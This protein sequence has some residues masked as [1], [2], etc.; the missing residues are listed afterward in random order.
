MADTEQPMDHVPPDDGV[1]REESSGLE[2]H[3]KSRRTWIRLLFMVL[4]GVAW[5]LAGLITW[6]VI[7]VNFLYVLFSGETN[8]QLTAFGHSLGMYLFQ[9][10]DFMT[11][12]TESRPFPIDEDWPTAA[13]ESDDQS[14]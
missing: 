9:I 1:A 12:N 3:V 10:V 11:F 13:A 6:V 4:M 7:F 8:R 14:L 2:K 5:S